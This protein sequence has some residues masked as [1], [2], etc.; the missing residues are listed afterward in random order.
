M[1]LKHLEPL[2]DHVYPYW[3]EEHVS[4]VA[5]SA[6]GIPAVQPG[7]AEDSAFNGSWE[8][9]AQRLAGGPSCPRHNL[10]EHRP[11]E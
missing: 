2:W 5:A 8:M 6:D 9:Y 7:Q 3:G 4:Q 10:A 1:T 11:T